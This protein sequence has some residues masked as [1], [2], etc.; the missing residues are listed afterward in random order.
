M[1][2]TNEITQEFKAL[3]KREYN[4]EID[5]ATAYESAANFLGLFEV[6]YKIDCRVRQ[7]KNP[8]KSNHS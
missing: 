2:I 3:W 1:H 6:L 4:E 7:D 8:I 5:D